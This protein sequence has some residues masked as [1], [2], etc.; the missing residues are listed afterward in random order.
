MNH[1]KQHVSHFLIK[2]VSAGGG[3]ISHSSATLSGRESVVEWCQ[4]ESALNKHAEQEPAWQRGGQIKMCSDIVSD[5]RPIRAAVACEGCC[6]KVTSAINR[7][8]TGAP[9]RSRSSCFGTQWDFNVKLCFHVMMDNVQSSKWTNHQLPP[10]GSQQKTQKSWRCS[11]RTHF[12]QTSGK[13]LSVFLN[14][15]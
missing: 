2:R 11:L 10:G 9:L 5:V 13:P 14:K 6:G 1:N 7:P 12:Q 8:L 4:K 3:V 15:A